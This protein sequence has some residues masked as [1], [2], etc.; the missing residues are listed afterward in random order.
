ADSTGGRVRRARRLPYP[1]F[2]RRQRHED[3]RLQGHGTNSARTSREPRSRSV[4]TAASGRA[5]KLAV[6]GGPGT[7]G[8]QIVELIGARDFSYAELKLFA[9]NA[10]IAAE[11]ESGERSMPVSP[12]ESAAD[13]A[14]FDIAILAIPES[15][16][17]GVINARPGP[18]LIDLSAAT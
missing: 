5:I 10:G 7:V 2:G 11:V 8:G 4:M 15:E 6:G 17:R 9:T 12:L 18:V 14:P 1:R 3:G 13:L 16:A